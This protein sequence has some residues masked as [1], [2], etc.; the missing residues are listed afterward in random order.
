VRSILSSVALI[1]LVSSAALAQDTG[2]ISGSVRDNTGAVVSNAHVKISTA[3]GTLALTTVS[4]SEGEYSVPG[5]PAGTYNLEINVNGF[6]TFSV[7]NIVLQ[8][9]QKARVDA[10]LTVGS[11]NETVVVQGGGV[12]QVDTASSEVAGTI[13]GTQ[14]SK[15]QM[16]GRVFTSLVGLQPGV[17]DPTEGDEQRTGSFSGVSPSI[18]GGR[19]E[20]SNWQV[21]GGD[22]Q[23]T[24]SNGTLVVYPNVDAIAEVRVLESSYGA[25]Y[26]KNGS[27]TIEVE[28]KSGT[29]SFHGNL[30]YYGRNEFLNAYSP[31]DDRT[32]AKPPYK[33]HDF[34]YT[35][36]GPVYVPG[37][38]NSDKSKTFFFWSQEWRREKDPYA[39]HVLVPSAAE[40]KGDFSHT[41]S[42]NLAACPLT[43]GGGRFSGDQVPIDPNAI[44][45][46]PLI[47]TANTTD[48]KGN[49]QYTT[50]VS[51]PTTSREELLRIDHNINSKLRATFSY[52]HD[53]YLQVVPYTGWGG[54]SFPTFG[55]DRNG[56]G[57]SIV[58]RLTAQLSPTL[59][60]EFV[61]GYTANRLVFSDNG[62]W[63]RSLYSG[64]FTGSVFPNGFGGKV[65]GLSITDN[66]ESFGFS[67]DPSFAPWVNSNPTYSYRDNVSKMAGKHSLQFGAYFQSA[68][69]NEDQ[70][71]ENEGLLSFNNLGSTVTSGNG[72]AD[73]LLGNIQSFYQENHQIKYYQ[74]YKILEPYF[75]DDWRATSRLT[76]NLGF[77]LS[78]FGT[79]RE[80][81]K[82]ATNFNP[83]TFNPA[84]APQVDPNTG[85]FIASTTANPFNGL[86]EC[87]GPGGSQ[88]AVVPGGLFP[89]AAIGGSPYAGCL[90]GHL[91]NPAPRIGFAYDPTGTGKM[92]I[93]AGYG[94]FYEHTNGTEANTEG[95]EGN[96]P[97]F[98]NVTQTNIAG[99]GNIGGGSGGLQFFPFSVVSIPN[100][101]VWPYMQQWHWDVQRQLPGQTVLVVAYVG[102]KGTHLTTQ[103]DMNQLYPLL[104]SQDPYKPGEAINAGGHDD[105]GT[106]TTP[107]GVPIT[108][109]ALI[110]LN[111]ACGMNPTLAG[112]RLFP[113]YNALFR[114]DEAASS[115]YH[116]LQVSARRTTGPLTYSV[117]YTYSH[118]I[119]NAS[120]R[121]DNGIVDGYNPSAARA[122]SNFDQRHILN[123]SYFYEIPAFKG[124]GLRH[125]LLGGWAIS[126]IT[127]FQSGQPFSVVYGNDNAGVSNADGLGSFADVVGDPN[128]P[129]ATKQYNG[130]PVF[131]NPAAFAAPRGLTF[132]NSGRNRLNLP[133]RTNFDMGLFK[134]FPV[135]EGKS[136][137]F[138]WEAF[139]VF[140]HAQYNAMDGTITDAGFLSPTSSHAGRI[141]QYSL[142]FLF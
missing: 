71:A 91:L 74:R 89:K 13:T 54:G 133:F 26:G 81:Y 2:V 76:F 128:T 32:Q 122:S 142:K 47:P 84:A 50:S 85:V 12:A 110:H 79:Y 134:S 58:A 18:N 136:F 102:S 124:E 117:A 123:L 86:V 83:D 38:Y 57:T 108:G 96:A 49:P 59:F 17:A 126:G 5:L 19:A 46:L 70:G 45:L 107:S 140:N 137:E 28:T 64:L 69:K 11:V 93:R 92:A 63:Q 67:L 30:F 41:C 8:V 14:I 82:Q 6:R 98:L 104:L 20:Y 132:G 120:G 39:Y 106:Q 130:K 125:K 60:N 95:L 97:Q 111:V 51:D 119:D 129:P 24:G 72:F 103:H 15:L 73:F 105:C 22:N 118:S 78:L 75:Q 121:A 114:F 138:R 10:I 1:L 4:N 3:V 116:S 56:P 34:G 131:Y 87:G 29:K 62:R 36:G 65:S 113:A 33:K 44:L 77:R 112:Y 141:V 66:N 99:Y 94:I 115:T 88:A 127:L 9:A 80:R 53:S 90:K 135:R 100:K 23:D 21:N 101:V 61:A 48:S 35:I 55:S 27:G 109:Q 16:N 25:Q 43:S 68:Q 31:F 52:I 7:K 42:V 40:R 37:H 139:N